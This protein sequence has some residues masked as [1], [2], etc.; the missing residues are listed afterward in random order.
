MLKTVEELDTHIATLTRNFN[1]SETTGLL[2]DE[3]HRVDY[4]R[5]SLFGHPLLA[6]IL[7]Q[8]NFEFPDSTLVTYAQ[9]TAYVIRYLPNLKT[10]HQSSTRIQ[11]NIVT[12]DAYAALQLETKQM[13]DEIQE[14]KRKQFSGKT[15][16]KNKNKNINKRTAT[17]ER[18]TR[19]GDENN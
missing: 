12:S 19:T 7:K 16:L 1:I 6:E 18:P 14:L 11:A 8:F 17:R 10:V 15:K 2:V 13:K 4:F 3:D 9:I 5:D